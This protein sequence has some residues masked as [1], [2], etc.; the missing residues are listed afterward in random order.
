MLG[1]ALDGMV[2]CAGPRAMH[3]AAWRG[4]R[5]NTEGTCVVVGPLQ[6][7]SAVPSYLSRFS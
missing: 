1:D 5:A 3:R 6:L 2:C 4:L 7:L